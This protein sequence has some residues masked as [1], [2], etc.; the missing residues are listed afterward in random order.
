MT[1]TFQR[2]SNFEGASDRAGTNRA[3]ADPSGAAARSVEDID[4]VSGEARRTSAFSEQAD[5]DNGQIKSTSSGGL[6]GGGR[7]WI[8]MSCC[9]CSVVIPTRQDDLQAA[10]VSLQEDYANRELPFRKWPVDFACRSVP[11]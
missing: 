6:A 3:R 1:V 10:I 2:Y 8:S 4:V 7:R 9:H 5:M 11:A